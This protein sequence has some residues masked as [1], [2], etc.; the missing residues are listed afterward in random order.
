[1][2]SEYGLNDDVPKPEGLN[3]PR[4]RSH[5]RLLRRL[6]IFKHRPAIIQLGFSSFETR[7]VID[8]PFPESLGLELLFPQL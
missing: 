6:I 2:Q 3:S 5:E 8:F 4:R 1:M 7:C